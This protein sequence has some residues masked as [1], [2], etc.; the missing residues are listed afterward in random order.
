MKK[1][2]FYTVLIITSLIGTGL[3]DFALSIWVL[4][5]PSY[6]MSSY[7]AIWFFESL[8]GFLLAPF[9]GSFIDRW[10]KKKMII[11]GQL[12]AGLVSLSLMILYSNDMLMPWHIM[13]ASMFAALANLF[14]FGAFFVATTAL[15]SK[16]K[17]MKAKGISGGMYA[18][19][20]M[21]IPIAAPAL[22]KL[23]GLRIIFLID[24]ISF[25]VSIIA[26]LLINFVVVAQ[27]DE[28]LDFKEDWKM[29]IR[30]LREKVGYAHLIVYSFILS[31]FWAIIQV[32]LV[33]LIL[34][35]SDEYTLGI[36]MSVLGV[37]GLVGSIILSVYSGFKNPIRIALTIDIIAGVLILCFLIDIS[38]Y[39]L[40]II[41]FI[42]MA[43]FT[44]SETINQVFY[45][46]TVPPKKLARM[47]GVEG[48]LSG[49]AE[50]L[51]FLLAG[52]FVGFMKNYT[53]T[54]SPEI[55]TYFPG[56]INT[57]SIIFV[58]IIAGIMII[59]TTLFFIRKKSIKGL[60]VLYNEKLEREKIRKKKEENET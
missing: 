3:T 8:P 47:A 30:F 59:F 23:L 9:V 39:T 45:Q 21:G 42:L 2:L 27:S 52:V 54:L 35:F 13:I 22:Y 38:V 10:S 29:V 49:G 33:P 51:A 32:L 58:F 60:D 53:E 31:F 24:I 41:G 55:R 14:V 40:A 48:I 57:I 18:I 26:F 19:L 43:L 11:Y 50:P 4:K 12:A 37:G 36:I 25:I 28:P 16:D 5:Q 34:D 20:S 46:T 15:V 6:S 17:L 7:S 1:Y 44:V 56:S